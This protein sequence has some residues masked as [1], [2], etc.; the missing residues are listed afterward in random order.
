MKWTKEK[1]LK[2]CILAF[3]MMMMFYAFFEADRQCV[4]AEEISMSYTSLTLTKGTAKKLKVRNLPN[5]NAKVVWG[6]TNEYAVTV[7]KKGKIKAVNYGTATIKARWKKKT[8]TCVV[9]VP[10]TSRNIMLNTQSVSL[11]EGT[12]YQLTAVSVKKVKYHSGNEAIATVSSTGLIT[13]VNPG[14]V[15]ITAKSTRGTAS[16]I[17]TVTS[18]DVEV[19]SPEWITNKSVTAVR[20]LTKNNNIVYDNI[21]W[22][23]GKTISFK[24]DNLDESTVKKCVWSSENN[25]ILS[26]PVASSTCK[27]QASAQT[28]A[29]GTTKV[30]ATVT[31]YN[32]KVK[33]YSNYVYVS[34]PSL[35]TKNMILLGTGAGSNRQQFIVFSGLTKYSTIKWTNS[36][37]ASA[38]FSSYNTKAAVWGILPGTGAITASVDGKTY[39]INYTVY[40]PVFGS[41]TSVLAAGKT[42]KIDIQG[43]EGLSPVYTSRNGTIAK[44]AADGTI[45][46]K[47]A[48]VTYID[49]KLD[50]MYFS[51]RIE[52]SAKGIRKIIN[53][54]K[55]IVNNWK[56]SQAKRM[57]RGYYDC[58]ALVWK[59]YKA[60][61][62]YH[63]KLGSA[64]RALPAGE[65]FDYLYSKNQIVYFGYTGLDNLKPGD[66]IF[67][68]DYDNA[69]KYSTPGRT[70]DI[71]HVAMYA[72]NGELVEKGGQVLTYE[73]T[74]YIV[75][76]G[77]VVK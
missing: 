47:K 18:S 67:Y 24:I 1:I 44:V 13:A 31:D 21:S 77:R 36:N 55:F 2:N 38:T 52:I 62:Q 10:D 9:S 64:I 4:S 11:A 32:G 63:K 76:I 5:S 33:E 25:S 20:R 3:I 75:G 45:T 15:K 65:L 40:N 39:T 43:L 26:K 56:Y 70:L 34:S 37:Y 30:V 42:T 57:K 28:L 60:Y 54:A 46:G 73:G 59:G 61:K 48:G 12:T 8:V 17:V 7:S 68:G 14:I 51:Y 53:R 74:K 69:V 72:G 41:I 49:V 27:I 66:L 58:S 16:C 19:S 50:N 35:N 23:K 22:A 6:T 71:Y 29:A